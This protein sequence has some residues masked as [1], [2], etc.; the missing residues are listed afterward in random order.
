MCIGLLADMRVDMWRPRLESSHQGGHSE[1]R[2]VSTRA[3]D[4][5]SAIA[6]VAERLHLVAEHRLV[7]LAGELGFAPPPATAFH[8]AGGRLVLRWGATLRATSGC[9]HA[10]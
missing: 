7:A 4:M 8:D 10:A 9:S 6:V 5:P 1:Y 3:V 2:R